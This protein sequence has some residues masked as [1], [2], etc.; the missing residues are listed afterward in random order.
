[1][2]LFIVQMQIH[3]L[4]ELPNM[5]HEVSLP[6]KLIPPIPLGM[7]M[8]FVFLIVSTPLEGQYGFKLVDAE[9]S[10]HYYS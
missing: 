2:W 5:H 8:Y 6:F 7:K 4:P 1:M 9:V 10:G 3:S